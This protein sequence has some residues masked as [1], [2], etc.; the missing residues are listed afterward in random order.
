M[1]IAV[2]DDAMTPTDHAEHL[3][4]VAPAPKRLVMQRNTTHYAAYKQYGP[5]VIPLM[6]EWLR[7]RMLR[8]GAG[9]EAR[10]IE[11][12]GEAA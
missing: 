9:R 2:A 5:Q 1:V 8:D 6:V 7:A 10:V 3:Y 11:I 4:E 12:T